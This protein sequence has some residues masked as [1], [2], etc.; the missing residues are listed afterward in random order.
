MPR[1]DPITTGG[2]PTPH[3]DVNALLRVLHS[4]V[5]RILSHAFAG[6]Y[7]CG[8][9]A[10]GN[11]TA[12][13]DV[14]VVVA[15][16]G[17]LAAETLAALR[18]MHMR[19]FET[20]MRWSDQL[21][22]DYIPL[23]GLRRHDPAHANYPHL[24]RGA[25][26]QLRII[27][28]STDSVVHRAILRERGIVLAGPPPTALIDPITP[29]ELRRAQVELMRFW[30]APMAGEGTAANFLRQS[31]HQSLAV[32]TMCRMLY[33]LRTGAIISK[34]AAAHWGLATLDP[35]WSG[36]IARADAWRAD[37]A[38]DD[39]V[40]APEDEIRETQALIRL[41]ADECEAWANTR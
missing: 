40:L 7:L 36:L 38:P 41:V 13:S 34:S 16:R 22:V 11:L 18:A 32:L 9:L 12:G 2:G 20:G 19:L 5:T 27:T 21:E 37:H 10:L 30:W 15:T 4:E 39:S 28:H 24:G 33:T 8:S 29:D 35:R 6:M 14:D 31:G 26:E 1:T 23:A 3:E 17:E 25:G